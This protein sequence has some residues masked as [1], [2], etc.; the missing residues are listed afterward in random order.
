MIGSAATPD[1]LL[2]AAR[3]HLDW[4]EAFG[5]DLPACAENL[6]I[7]WIVYRATS[8]FFAAHTLDLIGLPPEDNGHG[9]LVMRLDERLN[10][11]TSVITHA[12]TDAIVAGM[13]DEEPEESDAEPMLER[14]LPACETKQLGMGFFNAFVEYSELVERVDAVE[15]VGD[16]LEFFDAEIAWTE[17]YIDSLPTCAEAIEAT[18]LMFRILADYSSSFALLVAGVDFADIPYVDVINSNESLLEVWIRDFLQ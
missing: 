7:F 4:R 1:A 6:E 8:A 15:N 13:D 9:Q 3:A 11:K 17:Q 16:I 14:S 12:F 2:D 18:L 10:K 5:A